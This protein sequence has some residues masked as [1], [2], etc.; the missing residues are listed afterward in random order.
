MLLSALGTA[1]KLYPHQPDIYTFRQGQT[2]RN[3]RVWCASKTKAK[4]TRCLALSLSL[5]WHDGSCTGWSAHRNIYAS[6]RQKDSNPLC[7]FRLVA[8]CREGIRPHRRRKGPL[9]HLCEHFFLDVL[10]VGCIVVSPE[11]KYYPQV[12]LLLERTSHVVHRCSSLGVLRVC[13]PFFSWCCGDCSMPKIK[14]KQKLLR[15]YLWL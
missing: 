3:G 6:R 9:M 7:I 11:V 8:A 14:T 15:K 13:A 4:R 1:E 5:P 2:E 12:H 10:T